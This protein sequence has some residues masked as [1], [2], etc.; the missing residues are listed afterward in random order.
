MDIQ[1][2][3][4]LGSLALACMLFLAA[5]GGGGGGGSSCALGSSAGCGGTLPVP[6]TT[7][8]VTPP[9]TPPVITPAP[10]TADPAA[11]AA[12]LSLVFSSN[13]LKSA[14]G[15][16][17]TITA[18]VKNAGNAA[19][20]NA[21]IAFAADSGLLS[22]M[23]VSTDASGRAKAV[24]DTGGLRSNRNITVSAKVG[25]Q[26]A[27]GVV[28]VV[29]TS[30]LLDG[31]PVLPLG[32]SG[33]LTL[34]LRDAG[35][36][37][38]AGAQFTVSAAHGNAV[39]PKAGAQTDSQGRAIIVVQ[40]STVGGETVTVTAAGASAAHALAIADGELT[41]TPA[42]TV[43]AAGAE[44]VQQVATGNCQPIDGHYTGLA[45]GGAATVLLSTSRGGVY[46]DSA[47][48]TP[49]AAPL[50]VT[51]GAMQ[52][53]YVASAYAG[54]ATLTATMPGG[55]GAVSKV[56]FVAPLTPSATLTLQAD[57]PTLT[58]NSA[59]QQSQRSTLQAVVRDGTA[60]N[61]LVK[62]AVVV[63]S[64]AAD[65]SGGTLLQPATVTTGSDGLAVA[66]YVAGSADSGR[67]GVTIQATIAGQSGART[68]AST[69][70]TVSRQA[71]SI[72]FGT[73]NRLTE[74][75][76]SLLQQQFSVLLA[77]AA[78]NAVAGQQVSAT[79]WASA[80]RKGYYAW[81]APS[82]ADGTVGVWVP[83]VNYTCPN[84]DS[85]RKGLYDPALDTNAN[86]VL[87]PGIPVTVTVQ[88]PTDGLGL[89]TFTVSYPRDRGN[90][91]V[92]ELTARAIVSGTEAVAT[93][94]YLL[95][96]LSADLDKSDV[97]PPGQPS[98]YGMNACNQPD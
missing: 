84:E 24:L 8:P 59:G 81:R 18:L 54:V 16:P 58:S 20:A 26:T 13:E 98:P 79:A 6:P 21:A 25:T 73:G 89:T 27:S 87:D 7:S 4:T 32:K 35:G 10:P 41:L 2:R 56:E 51:G 3:T 68:S 71:L 36:Q 75:S 74:Y 76:A 96:A 78:G 80:F 94:N 55:P 57:H 65:A 47:C 22:G 29:G 23:Q 46:A 11:N 85:L 82:T 69:R 72:Q 86:G 17:V 5:C 30:L 64:I 70:L 1:H 53:A 33:E 40:A 93:A 12:S 43:D 92:L 66:T 62:N 63:F 97:S 34:T 88:G 49:L 14:G 67:D 83:V 44:V 19:L 15:T 42:V 45:T 50:P 52:R 9:A 95:P 60:A 90:W 61:N 77:D 28:T 48:R 39:A 31:P 38:I 91:L 37:P